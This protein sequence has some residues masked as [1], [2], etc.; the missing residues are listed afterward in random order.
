VGIGF[1][2]FTGFDH[3][4]ERACEKNRRQVWGNYDGDDEFE[5]K[6]DANT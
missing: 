5:S 3:F 6:G 4:S 2:H 1:V